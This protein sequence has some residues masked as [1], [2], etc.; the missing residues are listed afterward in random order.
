MN[1]FRVL[2]IDEQ[3]SDRDAFVRYVH[4]K[5]DYEAIEPFEELEELVDYVQQTSPHAV[6]LD[7]SLAEF[8]PEVKYDGVDAA[9]ALKQRNPRFPVFVLTTY[10]GDAMEVAEDV[11]YIY[12]KAAISPNDGDKIKFI[13]RLILQIKHYF[14]AL[15]KAQTEFEALIKKAEAEALNAEEEEQLI[16]LDA[17]LNE[18]VGRDLDIPK[19][20]KTKAKA[21]Q[22]K[23][24]IE[25]TKQLMEKISQKK[26]E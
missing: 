23:E 25:V 12:P 16:E 6:V 19:H 2:Y 26:G 14:E 9:K 1:E 24:L 20:L 22:T 18:Q 21:D 5:I 3:Q 11:N 17:F 7:H 4:N 10:D 13:D 15:E 8:K